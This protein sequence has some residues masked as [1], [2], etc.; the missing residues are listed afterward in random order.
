MF[1]SSGNTFYDKISKLN[2]NIKHDDSNCSMGVT[3]QLKIEDSNRPYNAISLRSA[4]SCLEVALDYFFYK[5]KFKE[6]VTEFQRQYSMQNS[7]FYNFL[8]FGT[9]QESIQPINTSMSNLEQWHS[10]TFG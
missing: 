1:S 7:S 10:P 3:V 2:S 9:D 6:N 5:L 8:Q 4:D